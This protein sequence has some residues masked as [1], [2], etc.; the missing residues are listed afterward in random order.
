MHLPK[1]I[2]DFFPLSEIAE[3][4]SNEDHRIRRVGINYSAKRSPVALK[5]IY[6]DIIRRGVFR[7]QAQITSQAGLASYPD[8]K[9]GFKIPITNL[10]SLAF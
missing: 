7:K 4:D 3:T 1:P 10:T 6:I 5:G 8:N 2:M 9:Q